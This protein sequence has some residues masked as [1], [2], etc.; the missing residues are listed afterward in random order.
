M[1]ARLIEKS[2]IAT[3]AFGFAI[4]V[5]SVVLVSCGDDYSTGP[6]ESPGFTRKIVVDGT[7]CIIYRDVV[8]ADIGVGGISCDWGPQ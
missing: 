4:G 8:D 5:G 1:K 3:A 2:M 6:S 7:T